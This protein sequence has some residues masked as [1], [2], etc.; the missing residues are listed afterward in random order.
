MATAA[1][2]IALIAC[3]ANVFT[4]G[5]VLAPHFMPRPAKAPERLE[6]A[7]TAKENAE[8]EELLKKARKQAQEEAEAFLELMNYNVDTAYGRKDLSDE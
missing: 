1:L 7:P 6:T 5:L 2:I 3:M 8:D 4:L